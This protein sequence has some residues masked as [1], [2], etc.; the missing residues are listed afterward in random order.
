M[1]LFNCLL[2]IL[3]LVMST[4]IET[5]AELYN[6][7]V[8]ES[9]YCKTFT[10]YLDK[11]DSNICGGGCGKITTNSSNPNTFYLGFYNDLV[12]DSIQGNSAEFE[13]GHNPTILSPFK[14]FCKSAPSL[15]INKNI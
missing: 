13:C 7:F 4:F 2:V 14:I 5:N 9:P 11:C 3:L 6:T 8:L 1:K 12:C 10:L 15:S